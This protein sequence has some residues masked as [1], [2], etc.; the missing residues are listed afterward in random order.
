[1]NNITNDVIDPKNHICLVFSMGGILSNVMTDEYINS[2]DIA[3]FISS[4]LDFIDFLCV[5]LDN[6]FN[7]D[8]RYLL[9]YLSS[10]IDSDDDSLDI[11]L[12]LQFSR[13][14][15]NQSLLT[16]YKILHSIKLNGGAT[17]SCE[18]VGDDLI[19]IEFRF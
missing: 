19:K 5:G 7:N 15:I 1:M 6:W 13:D 14:I 16:N 17:H 2:P 11:D 9:D 10:L 4:D 8:D 12:I 3:Y 18:I